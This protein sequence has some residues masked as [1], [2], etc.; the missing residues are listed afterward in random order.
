MT[1][2]PSRQV[3]LLIVCAGCILLILIG[4]YAFENPASRWP[5]LGVSLGAAVL[6]GGLWYVLFR[7]DKRHWYRRIGTLIGLA[8]LTWVNLLGGGFNSDFWPAF[9]LVTVGTAALLSRQE[10]VLLYVLTALALIVVHTYQPPTLSSYHL[11]LILVRIGIVVVPAEMYRRLYQV[12]EQHQT[13]LLRV[14]QRQKE[15]ER[16]LTRRNVELNLL[17]NVALALNSTLDLDRVLTRVIELTNSSMGI[18]VGSVSLL[19]Q[20]TGELV[21]RTLV[22]EGARSVDGLRIPKGEGIGGWVCQHDETVMVHNVQSD[23]RF[24]R[25]VDEQSGFTTRSMICVPLR[26]RDRVIGVI[27]AINKIHGRF[28]REDEQLL[29]GLSAIAAPAIENAQLHTRLRQVNE[30]LRQ[31]YDE[32]KETQDQLVAAEKK[33]A[34]VELAGAAA[35]Q[36]NQPLTV[37]LCS[38]GMIR[39]ALPLDHEV[40]SDLDVIEKAVQD[41]TETVKKIGSITEYKTKTYV[42]G[43]QILDLGASDEETPDLSEE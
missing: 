32:L 34:A 8:A 35:H 14:S 4:A 20:Q 23:P 6:L 33:A 27:E 17:N 16:D 42:E 25:R 10:S 41:A 28:V 9:L 18:E 36:L 2:I 37:I 38:L 39:R 12:K 21:I 43:I 31:R 40:L 26:S 5:L 24:Y 29:E 3:I 15:I 22:G 30:A 11:A 19:D 7:L 1:E 13:E